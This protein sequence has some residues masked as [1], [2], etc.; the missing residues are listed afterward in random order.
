MT[1]SISPFL[2]ENGIP[3]FHS[4]LHSPRFKQFLAVLT[5]LANSSVLAVPRAHA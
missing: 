5:S 2:L 4:L 1:T 3:D